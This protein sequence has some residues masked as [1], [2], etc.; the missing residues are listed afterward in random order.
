MIQTITRFFNW[1]FSTPTSFIAFISAI[2]AL[3]AYIYQRR[4]QK[5]YNAYIIAQKYAKDLLPKMRIIKKI[6]HKIE[7]TNYIS[8][9][10]NVNRF[11]YSE[12]KEI[13]EKN[14]KKI[15]DF[16]ELFNKITLETWKISILE[17][18]SDFCNQ[19]WYN[20]ITSEIN[21]EASIISDSFEKFVHD[22][23]NELE[24]IAISLRYDIADEKLIYQSLHQTFLNYMNIFYYFISNENLFGENRYYEN[25]I[26]LYKK[27]EKRKQEQKQKFEKRVGNMSVGT[28]V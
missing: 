10:T 21:I 15:E 7:A 13:F 9:F 14:N 11:D 19:A 4:V 2:I 6:F 27:W 23:L 8:Q 1:F 12:L 22:L 16:K 18:G 20:M 28:K 5:K 24:A 3:F 25:I 17:S 26:W